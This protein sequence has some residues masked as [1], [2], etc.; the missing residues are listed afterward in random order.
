MMVGNQLTLGNA[1]GGYLYGVRPGGMTFPNPLFYVGMIMSFMVGVIMYRLLSSVRTFAARHFAPIV[2]LWMI[3]HDVIE[4]YAGDCICAGGSCAPNQW[5]ALMLAPV[6]GIQDAVMTRGKLGFLPW[7]TTGNYVTVADGAAKLFL[8]QATEQ[9]K[10]KWTD[11]VCLM[12]CTISG[13]VAGGTYASWST[14]YLGGQSMHANCHQTWGLALM[15][16]VLGMLFWLHDIATVEKSSFSKRRFS[17]MIA[18]RFLESE[19]CIGG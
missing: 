19:P 9:E 18:E 12:I 6:F 7:C 3:S 8:G 2:F 15:A 1:V 11:S 4:W 13:C 16:P 5:H 17:G 14:E 10:K